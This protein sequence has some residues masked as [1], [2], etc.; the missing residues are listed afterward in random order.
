MPVDDTSA[1]SSVQTVS[2]ET[3]SLY[4]SNSGTRTVD[5]GQAAGTAVVGQLAFKNILDADGSRIGTWKDKSLSFTGDCLT[6]ERKYNGYDVESSDVDTW[7]NKL[8]RVT[9]GFAN[10][11]YCVDYRSGTIYG[12]KTTTTSS[13]TSASYKVNQAQSGGATTLSSGVQGNVAH[14]AVDSGNPVKIGGKASTAKP[15]AVSNADRVNAYFDEYGRLHTVD[16]GGSSTLLANYE[17]PYDGSATYTSNVTITCAGFPFTVDSTICRI[18]Y[19]AYKPSAG[20]WTVLVNG[21]NGV[22]MTSSSNVITVSGAG[23]PFASG[24]SYRVGIAYQTKGYTAGTASNRMQ[25]ID[26]ISEKHVEETLIAVTNQTTNTTAYAYM[27]MDGY[28]TLALQGETSDTTPT[29]VLTVTVEASI[30]DDGT[31]AASCAYQD[32]T[33]LLFGVASWVDT[34]FF[35]VVNLPFPVKYIRVKYVTS[36][37]GGNDA[38]LTVYAKRMF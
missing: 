17:S 28:S 11:E 5:A 31:A 10:G 34:D 35:G 13:L 19:I 22:S 9:S 3:V 15:S 26:P 33:N 29:D 21:T 2:G 23:T 38:D 12:I 30:E 27:D 4:Y 7:A 36:N 6:T 16:E 24:D 14:D 18:S 32:V 1:S 8:S 37:G 25:E 20:S